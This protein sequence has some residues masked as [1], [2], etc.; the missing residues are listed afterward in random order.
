M[1]VS[2]NPELKRAVLLCIDDSEDVLEWE[3]SF[4]ESF[5]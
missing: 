1:P 5:G 3:K 4:L 2:A